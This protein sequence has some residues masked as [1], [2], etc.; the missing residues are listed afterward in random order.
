MGRELVLAEVE[1]TAPDIAV[2]PPEWLQPYL[3]REVTGEPEYEN[4]NL[5]G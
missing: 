5:A 3:I 4:R 2:V 1:L